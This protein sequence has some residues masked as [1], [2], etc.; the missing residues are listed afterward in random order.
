MAEDRRSAVM[1]FTNSARMLSA[2]SRAYR[3]TYAVATPSRG[4]T[5]GIG[6]SSPACHQQ[7]KARQGVFYSRVRFRVAVILYPADC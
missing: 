6:N 1:K 4:V 2:R 3:M 5:F 7:A